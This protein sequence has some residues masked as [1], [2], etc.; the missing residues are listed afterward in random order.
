MAMGGLSGVGMTA[1]GYIR[2]WEPGWIEVRRVKVPLSEGSVEQPIRIL[3]ATDLHASRVVSLKMIENGLRVG[4]AEKPDVVCLTG[5]FVTKKF[6]DT[7]K[8]T[9]M[10]RS[11]IGNVPT[12]ACLG[13]HDGGAWAARRRNGGYATHKTVRAMLKDA[14][15]QVLWNESATI[16]VHN[17]QIRLV[18]FGDLWTGE[19]DAPRAFGK[20]VAGVKLPTVVLSHNPDSKER[21]G[22]YPWDLALCG[23]THGGQ[24]GIFGLDRVFAPVRDKQYLSGLKRWRDR[25]IHVSRGIGNLHGLRFACRPDVSLLDIG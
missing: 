11:V 13:N 8:Y 7:A 5:D 25:W 3:H 18:G 23:H 20:P 4:M 17:R 16:Q 19:L 15:I 1:F 24:I 22:G 2:W 21:L 6:A 10:L 9:A 14:G 12:F